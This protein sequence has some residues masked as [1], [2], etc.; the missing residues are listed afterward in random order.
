MEV[1]DHDEAARLFTPLLGTGA[2]RKLRYYIYQEVWCNCINSI[3]REYQL[4]ID[5]TWRTAKVKHEKIKKKS[6]FRYTSRRFS[7]TWS[8][9]WAEILWSRSLEVRSNRRV[10]TKS[11]STRTT[12]NVSLKSKSNIIVINLIAALNTSSRW[13]IVCVARPRPPFE[14]STSKKCYLKRFPGYHVGDITVSISPAAG[15]T[16]W[17]DSS[18]TVS[19]AGRTCMATCSWGWLQQKRRRDRRTS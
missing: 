11:I 2:A 4:Y 13:L 16:C 9:C 19:P 14:R 10:T 15:W 8:T 12:T 18:A 7:I 6:I 3:I 1:L 5:E 17:E